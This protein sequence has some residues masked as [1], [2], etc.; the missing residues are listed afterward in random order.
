MDRSNAI[1]R[2]VRR[3]ENEHFLPQQ[4]PTR[5]QVT[6]LEVIADPIK[7]VCRFGQLLIDSSAHSTLRTRCDRLDWTR[8]ADTDVRLAFFAPGELF[9]RR[10][11]REKRCEA[12]RVVQ[13]KS[14]L[15]RWWVVIT[16]S[17]A[18]GVRIVVGRQ[19]LS[20]LCQYFIEGSYSVSYVSRGSAVGR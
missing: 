6:N 17:K 15:P 8:G 9:R 5:N 3:T 12:S 18:A 19:P 11:L 16:S 13:V 7:S 14:S 2:A 10:K 20:P 4:R 1:I